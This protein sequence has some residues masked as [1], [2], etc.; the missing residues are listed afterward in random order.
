MNLQRLT[1]EL[2]KPIKIC[3]YRQYLA[4]GSIEVLAYDEMHHDD[5]LSLLTH[6]DCEGLVTRGLNKNSADNLI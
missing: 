1:I 2:F 3:I 4:T 6:Q 5:S